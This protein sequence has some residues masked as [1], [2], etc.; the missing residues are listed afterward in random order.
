MTPQ[1]NIKIW[2]KL[3]LNEVRHLRPLSVPA[4]TSK[5]V[6]EALVTGHGDCEFMPTAHHWYFNGARVQAEKY[7]AAFLGAGT[8]WGCTDKVLSGSEPNEHGTWNYGRDGWC[9]GSSVKPQVFDVTDS[10]TLD[11][12]ATNN[13]TYFALSWGSDDDARF[14]ASM[15]HEYTTPTTLTDGCGGYILMSSNLVF[16]S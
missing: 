16:Y 14:D 2:T 8:M 11:P 1:R 4:K 15:H 5:V 9:D 12:D 7:E 10:V 3:P 6:L 13:I